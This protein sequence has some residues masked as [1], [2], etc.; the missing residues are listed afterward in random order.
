VAP[1]TP[2]LNQLRRRL[3]GLPH[4]TLL[5]TLQEHLDT[6]SCAA[7]AAD[8]TGRY[9]AVNVL[10]T[11]LT[12]YTREELMRM[13]VKDLTPPMRHGSAS[14]LWSKFIQAGTQAG[15]YV[16]LRK[17]GEPVGVKYE[18]YASVAPGVHLSLLTALEMPSSI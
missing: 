3:R 7:L 1:H 15:E 16:M 4:A 18:A 12:G 11:E 8:N 10:A 13:S 17:G 5:H 14:D 2:E 6:L 9:V